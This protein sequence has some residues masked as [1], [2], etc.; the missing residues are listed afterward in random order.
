MKAILLT[1]LGGADVLKPQE[2]PKPFIKNPNEV[3][4]KIQ[5]SGINFAEIL[6]R[7]GLYKW[8][9]ARKG[10][11][12]GMEGAGIV[13]EVG[14]EVTDFKVGDP[15]IVAR[16][17]GCHAEYVVMEE[18]YVFPA[19]QRLSL[20]QNAAF[21]GSFM[22]AYIALVRMARV[23]LGE[24]I[25]VQAAAGA[26]GTATVMLAK[27]LGLKVAGTASSPEKIATLHKLG[28]ELAINYSKEDFKELAMEWTDNK[29]VNVVLES[30]GGKI[31]NKSMQCLSPMGRLIFVG[32]SSVRFNK[33]NPLTWWS[34]YRLIPRVNLLDMLGKS[35]GILAFHVGRLLDDNYTEIKK[36]FVD[37]VDLVQRHKIFPII[38]KIYQLNEITE[39]HRMI[40]SRRNIGKIILKIGE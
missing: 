1:K 38:G 15:V 12:L 30:V 20:E 2:V 23:E 19:L 9:P 27:A 29:G 40:E 18:K 37:L 16:G 13:E 36:S 34:T 17:F 8:V 25:L 11:I 22:T 14:D 7:R 3:L 39:A 28:I 33:Y 21:A 5:F 24:T 26:L 4:I 32:L 35:Q 6:A 31:F 10:F